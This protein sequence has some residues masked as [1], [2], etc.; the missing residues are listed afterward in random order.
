MPLIPDKVEKIDNIML[1]TYLLTQHN[2]NK[3]SM[4][5]INFSEIIGVTIHNTDAIS[6]A[7]NTTPAEQYT[8]ATV[9]GNMKDVRVHFYVD[10]ECIWQNLPLTLSGWHAADGNGNGNRKTI[11]I[12]I[13]GDSKKA[14]ENGIK[15]AAWLLNKYNLNIDHLYTHTYWLNVRDGKKG[16]LDSLNTQYNKYKMCP[17]YILPHWQEFKAKV[18]EKLDIKDSSPVIVPATETPKETIEKKVEIKIDPTYEKLGVV[19]QNE[20]DVFYQVYTKRKWL[21]IVKNL[22][23]YAGIK[24]KSF[25]CLAASTSQGKLTYRVHQLGSYWMKWV[26]KYDLNHIDGYAGIGGVKIDAVQV[27]FEGLPNYTVRYRV[28]AVGQDYYP[29]VV[30]ADN[31]NFAGLQGK[32]ID[33]IQIEIVKIRGND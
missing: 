18:R 28:A 4:P 24:G 5:T 30:G 3:I 10:D 31:N 9:N 16:T 7:S 12:E 6:V 33:R 32:Q 26:N 19:A 20:V 11:A 21:P 25:T 27:K 15:L 14:E 17:S 1:K 29:W 23:D 2:P 13:I 8:R 22:E